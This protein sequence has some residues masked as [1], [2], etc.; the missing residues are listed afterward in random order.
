MVASASDSSGPAACDPVVP[1]SPPGPTDCS[2]SPTAE[3]GQ[4]DLAAADP[5]APTAAEMAEQEA[6][7]AA[8]LAV[9][10]FEPPPEDQYASLL[11]DPDTGPPEGADAW[12]G[13]LASPARDALLDARVAAAGPQPEGPFPADVIMHDQ[14]GPGGPGFASG[15]A[16]DQLEPGPVLAAALDDAWQA[17]WAGVSD[18][19]LAGIILAW[20]R[21]ESRASAGLLA[22]TAELNRRRLASGD[23]RVI[24]HTDNELALLLTLTRRSAG[25]LLE[26]A[27]NLARLPATQAALAAGRIDRARADVIAYETGLLD[28]QLAAAVE[29][30]VVEDAPRLTTSGLRARLRSAVIAADPAAARRRAEKAARDARVELYDERSGGTA[31]LTGRDLPVGAALAADQR[32]DTAARTLKASGVRAT[33]PQLR[34]AVFLGLLTGH[35]P[36]TFL[37]PGDPSDN[38]TQTQSGAPTS[39]N[40][41][42]ADPGTQPAPDSH[43]PATPAHHNGQAPSSGGPDTQPAPDSDQPAKPADHN[44]QASPPGSG[45]EPA[46]RGDQP[47]A[48]LG[49]NPGPRQPA[50]STGQDTQGE[51]AAGM[52]S[53]LQGQPGLRGSVNLTVPLKAWLGFTQSP[54]EIT[55][56]GPVTA[57][58]CRDLASH[59]AA[60]PGS[61][62]C[63][64]LTDDAGHAV[65][66][67]CARRPPPPHTD[68]AAVTAWLRSLKTSPVEAGTC[69]HAREVPGYRIPDSLAHIINI[70]QKTCANPVCGRPAVRCDGDHTIPYDKGGRTC[71]CLVAPVCRT[72]HQA[73][74]APGWHLEQP[75]PGVLVWQPPHGR[76]YTVTPGVYPT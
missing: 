54:G 66:H 11:A 25:T 59:I 58:S 46:D 68:L 57:E 19:E 43:Q 61:R 69:S 60:N 55:A 1:L 74:Q 21:C 67:G 22:A 6:I 27:A 73:K 35:D 10:V 16:L 39:Q 72:E 24:E 8:E 38:S 20:R 28:D 44:G 76:R 56:F 15:S 31:A 29:Q 4:A 23:W 48:P 3:I 7:L 14:A 50:E 65:G 34:A 36:R 5:E 51:D 70:R 52:P 9:R 63:L 32:I 37:P 2:G 13:E 53:W 64:T 30:L 75:S 62:W 17:G 71:E 45:T 26:L 33:L 42:P 49:G 12:L 40:V 18:D 41:Q 47:A